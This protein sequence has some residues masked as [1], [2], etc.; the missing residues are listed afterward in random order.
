M[1]GQLKI[2]C[3]IIK[4]H[5]LDLHSKSMKSLIVATNWSKE[6]NIYYCYSHF[7]LCFKYRWTW[8]IFGNIIPTFSGRKNI[9]SIVSEDI[10]NY[11]KE[12]DQSAHRTSSLTISEFEI[13]KYL[14]HRESWISYSILLLTEIIS[15]LI[16]ITRIYPFLIW[17]WLKLK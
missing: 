8:S 12:M 14:S 2:V 4:D 10:K 16:C 6:D 11:G 1:D 17:S 7:N 15:F 13:S 3:A 5:E 9:E